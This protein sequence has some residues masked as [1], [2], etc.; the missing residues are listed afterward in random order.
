MNQRNRHLLRSGFTAGV[1]AGSLALS[2]CHGGTRPATAQPGSASPI[3]AS[4]PAS[5]PA[6]VPAPSGV[7]AAP[8]LSPG[9]E[10]AHNPAANRAP[11]TTITGSLLWFQVGHKLHRVRGTK[12]TTVLTGLGTYTAELSPDGRQIAYIAE[13]AGRSEGILMVAR[14]DGSGARKLLSGVV[15]T[16]YGPAW[17]PDGTRILTALDGGRIRVG[18]VRVSDARFTAL[19]KSLQDGS[20]HRWSG[21]GRN[22]VW[23]YGDGKVKIGRPD[24]T[25]IR[26]VP[27]LGDVDSST[28]PRRQRAWNVASVNH[29]GTRITANL[30]RVGTFDGATVDGVSGSSVI[31]TATGKPLPLPVR[32]TIEQAL[33]RADGTLLVASEFGGKQTLTLLSRNDEV[34]ATMPVPP[35]AKGLSLVDYAL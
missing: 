5:A 34:L 1:L 29:D 7:V 23:T 32:G 30:I 27:S 2:G 35:G 8:S 22:I 14:S 28:N 13:R 10:P 15:T 6:S 11:A 3:P 12:R 31:D 20:N 18:A 16:G 21:D 17:S 19:P 24:G 4:A 26:R 9:F 33:H 25:G